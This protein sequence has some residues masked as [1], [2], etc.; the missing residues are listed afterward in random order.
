MYLPICSGSMG[1][2]YYGFPHLQP[3]RFKKYENGK[4][5]C[6]WVKNPPSKPAQIIDR[7]E[8]YYVDGPNGPQ[9]FYKEDKLDSHIIEKRGGRT[10]HWC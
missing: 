8:S 1:C 3:C 2:D 5:M 6:T 10:D 4:T 9:M 7:R